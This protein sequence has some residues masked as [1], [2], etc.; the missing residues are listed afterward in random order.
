[1]YNINVPCGLIF[2]DIVLY[3]FPQN[4]VLHK[5]ISTFAHMIIVYCLHADTYFLTTKS[6]LMKKKIKTANISSTI[7]NVIHII[8]RSPNWPFGFPCHTWASPCSAALSI[9]PMALPGSCFTPSPSWYIR[10]RLYMAWV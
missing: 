1:M 7:I 3:L 2:I 8:L 5:P 6:Y 4:Q 10:A 9:R